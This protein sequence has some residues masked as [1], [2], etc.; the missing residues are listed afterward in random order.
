[1]PDFDIVTDEH[2]VRHF[3]ANGQELYGITAVDIH[4]RYDEVPVVNLEMVVNPRQ[5]TIDGANVT[6]QQRMDI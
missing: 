6:A 3:Y 2:G 5:L 4:M 1:M